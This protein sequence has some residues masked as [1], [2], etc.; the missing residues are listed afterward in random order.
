VCHPIGLDPR[1]QPIEHPK[2]RHAAQVLD[3]IK[4]NAANSSLMQ[5]LQF[6]VGHRIFD[7]CH[8]AIGAPAGGDGVQCHVH[9]RA[10]ATR[11]DDDGPRDAQLAMQAAQIL[12]RRVRRRV[13]A[14][15]RKGK[16]RRGAKDMAMR[17]ACTRRQCQRGF[18]RIRIGR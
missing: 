3:E 11:V 12:D 7:A 1:E 15:G 17:I 18:F 6:C 4:A 16:F 2:V 10:M 5:A 14:V 8:P 13:A 9:L